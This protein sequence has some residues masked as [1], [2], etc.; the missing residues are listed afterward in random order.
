M[1]NFD[2]PPV[3]KWLQK[4]ANMSL[5]ELTRTF[6]CGIGLLIFVDTKDVESILKDVNDTGYKA[7]LIGSMIEKKSKRNVIFDGLEG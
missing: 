2:L 6:N 7:F 5:F 1:S 4:Q 3:F